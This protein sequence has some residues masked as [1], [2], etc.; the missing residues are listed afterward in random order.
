MFGWL[1]VILCLLIPVCYDAEIFLFSANSNKKIKVINFMLQ[2]DLTR[3]WQLIAAY[4]RS[5]LQMSD[6]RSD[7]YD[8]EKYF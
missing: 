3:S 6:A 2:D 4:N 1:Y 8:R 7:Q 5:N